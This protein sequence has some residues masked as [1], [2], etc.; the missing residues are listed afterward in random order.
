MSFLP[1]IHGPR[2]R[3][4][5]RSPSSCAGMLKLNQR[6]EAS[7]HV[8]SSFSFVFIKGNRHVGMHKL[9][10][11]MASFFRENLDKTPKTSPIFKIQIRKRPEISAFEPDL[12]ES[13]RE[14]VRGGYTPPPVTL[15][16]HA[17]TRS[18]VQKTARFYM[19]ILSKS[20]P[21]RHCKRSASNAEIWAL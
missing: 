5:L 3:L 20:T 1:H 19:L 11:V 10:A 7:D 8:N 16:N 14:A 4:S 12:L 15:S 2:R 13:L 6:N 18:Q 21:F 17:K 9:S